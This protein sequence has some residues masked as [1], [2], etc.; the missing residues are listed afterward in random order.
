MKGRILVVEDDRHQANALKGHLELEGLAVDAVADGQGAL[1]RLAD[2]DYDIVLSDLRL[3]DMD[4]LEIFRRSQR[5]RGDD[6]PEF[7]ILTAFGTVPSAREALKNGVRDYLQKPVD[8]SELAVLVAQALEFRRLK[9]ENKEL[10]AQVAG[11]SLEERIVGR[12]RVFMEMLELAKTAAESEATILIRGESGTGK[13]LVAELIHQGSPRAS[14]PFVKV[15]CAAIP[16]PLLEAELFGHEKGAFTDAKKQRRGRFE[17]AN[18]GTIFLDEIGEMTPNLQVKLLRVLQER[19]LE[20]LGSSETVPLDIR[21]VAATNRDLE[22]MI[23]EGDFREDLYYRINVITLAIPPLRDRRGDIPLLAEHFLER[24][25]AKNKKS[26]RG[27]SP[28]AIERIAGHAW[29]GNVRELE[30]VVERAVVLGR[31]ELVLPEHLPAAIAE[32]EAPAEDLVARVLEAG[33]SI[34]DLE[35]ELIGKALAQTNANVSKAARLLGLTRRMLQYRME[36]YGLEKSW[37]PKPQV[38]DERDRIR[39]ALAQTNANVSQAA[40]LLG[41][42]RRSLQYRMERH[43]ISKAKAR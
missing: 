18:G 4:G 14:G 31:G 19:E 39:S 24:F 6:A 32:H 16:E 43:G 9:R 33:I 2:G 3:P 36:K 10:K 41:L 37:I 1:A 17:M 35:R 15:N 7:L 38:E 20:R 11:R 27:L 13:E 34:D 21:L 42:T 5:A 29:P 30:N 22:A 8:A 23:K 40:R 26:F 12:A 25:N 28:E